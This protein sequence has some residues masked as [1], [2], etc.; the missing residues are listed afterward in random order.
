[1]RVVRKLEEEHR[2][3]PVANLAASFQAAVVDVLFLKTMKAAEKFGAKEI[4]VAGGVSANRALRDAFKQKAH[5]PVHIP[6]LALCTDNGAMIGSAGYFHYSPRS[7]RS[8]QPGCSAHLA[9][10]LM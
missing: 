6:P 8:A 9:A 10:F 2:P 3:I 4:V 1:M 5:L 7:Q